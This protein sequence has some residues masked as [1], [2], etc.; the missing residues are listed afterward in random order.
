[1]LCNVG[2]IGQ[3]MCVKLVFGQCQQGDCVNKY[4]WFV[5]EISGVVE[6]FVL[7]QFMQCVVGNDLYG[8]DEQCGVEWCQLFFIG[9]Q[10]VNGFV[11][12]VVE[13]VVEGV[14]VDIEV[15]WQLFNFDGFNVDYIGVGQNVEDCYQCQQYCVIGGFN[16]NQW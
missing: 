7:V 3:G 14:V 6:V 1:M 9:V 2:D 11:Q 10:G 8:G 13:Y 4:C 5:V 15:D 12:Y 16:L